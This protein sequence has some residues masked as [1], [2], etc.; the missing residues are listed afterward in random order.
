MVLTFCRAEFFQPDVNL[1]RSLPLLKNGGVPTAFNAT[2]AA[3]K[4]HHAKNLSIMTWNQFVKS[5]SVSFFSI[6]H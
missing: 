2:A 4:C 3:E 5:V 6:L 1:I